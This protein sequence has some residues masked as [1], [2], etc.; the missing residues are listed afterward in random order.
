MTW[1]AGERP[2]QNIQELQKDDTVRVTFPDGREELYKVDSV[3]YDIH[4][5]CQV[6]LIKE[7]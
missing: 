1:V 7:G 5:N 3:L 6:T 2:E 4:R